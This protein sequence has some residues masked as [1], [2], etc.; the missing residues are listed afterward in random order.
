[1][2]YQREPQPRLDPG[3]SR[4]LASTLVGNE[5]ATIQPGNYIVHKSR[6]L[7]GAKNRALGGL[8]HL[9]SLAVYCKDNDK[10]TKAIK[11]LEDMRISMAGNTIGFAKEIPEYGMRGEALIAFIGNEM[12]KKE[13]VREG[14]TGILRRPEPQT[15]QATEP[16]Q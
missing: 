10:K 13:N 15:P 2:A 12:P 16:T 5:N 9:Q 8:D 4:T 1:M 6:I 14:S 7:S 11:D 3:T